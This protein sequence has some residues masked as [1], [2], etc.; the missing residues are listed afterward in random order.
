M[1]KYLVGLFA[2]VLCLVL[3]TGCGSNSGTITCVSEAR[4]ADPSTVTYETYVVENNE[5][6]EY[7]KYKV[8]KFSDEYLSK[9]SIDSIFEIY[10]KDT[11]YTTEKVDGK[12]LKTTYI[13]PRNLYSDME[14]D[15]MIETIRASFEDNDFLMEKYTCEIK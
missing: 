1:K 4:G 11:S 3:V 8:L 5:I 2:I 12:T 6:T 14:T 10:D 13:A 9:V 7:T 15:N